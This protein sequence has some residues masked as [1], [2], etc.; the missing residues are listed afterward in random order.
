MKTFYQLLANNI[1]S[2]ITNLFLWASVI[3]WLYLETSS[4]LATSVIGG[5]FLVLTASS[6]VWFGAIVDHNKKKRAMLLS[7]IATLTFYVIALV[8][9]LSAP[10]G[11]FT[12]LS[13][14]Y[15][16]AFVLVIL[17][18]VTAGNIRNIA[19]PTLVAILVAEDRRDRANGL[20][21]TA[22]GIGFSLGNVAAGFA[23]AFTGMLGVLLLSIGA[24]A[25]ALLHLVFVNIEE[26][27]PASAAS[28]ETNKVDLRGTFAAVVAVPGL[29][30]LIFFTT[31]NNFLGGV[32][33]SLMD[34]YGLS[35]VSVQTWGT[36]WGFLSLGF[37]IGGLAIAKYGLGKNP[38]YRMF[39]VNGIL[40]VVCAIFTVQPSIILLAAGLFTYMCLMPGIEA[41]EHTIVQKVVPQERL[42]RVFGFAQ[43]VEQA[44]S[45]VSAFMIG[46]IAQFIFIPFMSEGGRGAALIG[47]W[48]GVG[49]GR[50]L[51]LVF[52]TVGVIGLIVTL[53]TAQSRSYKALSSQYK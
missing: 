1:L 3:Y 6:G 34:A 19:I 38:V 18:G 11:A 53:L 29:L 37:I 7:S 47:N 23:L 51:A 27:E 12:T 42:G 35:L 16:W 8:M 46:P 40:W 49:P 9:Y 24:S 15:L 22:T 13:S 41:A 39:L 33:M 5:I 32:F 44:A 25:L 4:V 45:P 30:A 2:G 31:F 26:Q 14:A 28:P 52:T 17:F 43:S 21:G 48:F 36:L 10:E 20:V 50:G